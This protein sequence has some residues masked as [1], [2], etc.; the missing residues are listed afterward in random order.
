[1]PYEAVPEKYRKPHWTKHTVIRP[2]YRR[3]A[4]G[5]AWSVFYLML[6]HFSIVR[7]VL[8]VHKPLQS[9]KLTNLRHLRLTNGDFNSADGVVYVHVDDVGA[10]HENIELADFCILRIA[11]A[12][13]EIGPPSCMLD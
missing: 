3:M 7:R 10:G 9:F 12:L 8:L 5:Q 2:Y 1:M 4:M 13:R 6:I 11:E